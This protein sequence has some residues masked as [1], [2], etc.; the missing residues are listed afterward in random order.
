MN[1]K[2]VRIVSWY[3]AG[4][5]TGMGVALYAVNQSGQYNTNWQVCCTGAAVGAVGIVVV[6]HWCA[7]L[8]RFTP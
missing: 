1:S 3:V 4:V 2:I 8:I 6:G 7:N 5:F